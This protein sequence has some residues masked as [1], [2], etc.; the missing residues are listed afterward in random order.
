MLQIKLHNSLSKKKEIFEP[1]E[2]KKIKIYACGPT[3]YNDIHVG[4]A[5][6]LIVFDILVRLLKYIYGNNSVIYVRNITDIDDKIIAK[7]K[8]ENKNW[9]ELSNFYNAKFQDICQK[10][11]LQEPNYQ[12]KATDHINEMIDIITK[13]KDKGFAYASSSGDMV[14]DVEKY[15]N[16]GVLSGRNYK[17]N[18]E[19]SRALASNYK[20]NS[21]DFVLWKAEKDSESINGKIV[22]W[23]SPFGK[24]RPG[25]HIECSAMA[26]YYLGEVFDIHTGGMDL[27]FPH[28]ENEI[29][30]SCCAFGVEKM[31]NYWLHNGLITVNGVKMSKSL[32]NFILAK[33]LLEKYDSNVIKFAILSTHYRQ[34][35]DLNSEL[36]EQSKKAI[37]KFK[38]VQSI[39]TNTVNNEV[40]EDFLLALSDDLNTPKA[41]SILH[42][43][44]NSIIKNPNQ[45][46]IN[47]FINSL[48]LLGIS[49]KADGGDELVIDDDILNFI[50]LRQEAKKNKNYALADEIRNNLLNLGVELKDTKNGEVEWK[51]IK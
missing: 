26:K 6:P 11:G 47:K 21:N 3:V 28:H 39:F 9:Q 30:Q 12:P 14:F 15:N 42:L 25:W 51:K 43:H 4:N 1:I 37:L 27:I 2:Q 50:N 41:I 10:L 49:F 22:S 33:D 16:Y 44:Y 48:S 29:A 32:G 8:E 38:E 35:F 31:A 40:L 36:L 7:A 5:R 19:G 24:G 23:Q 17:D 20:H 46:I 18:I 13:L 34:N 45:E